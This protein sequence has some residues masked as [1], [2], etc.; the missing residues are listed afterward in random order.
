MTTSVEQLRT[1]LVAS[2]YLQQRADR[3]NRTIG[4]LA[5]YGLMNAA[6]IT[7]AAGAFLGIEIDGAIEPTIPNSKQLCLK[8]VSRAI[9]H[10]IGERED[11]EADAAMSQ[12]F[13]RSYDIGLALLSRIER[14]TSNPYNDGW[15]PRDIK[16]DDELRA[17]N[18]DDTAA[19]HAGNYLATDEGRRLLKPLEPSIAVGQG[20]CPL[21]GSMTSNGSMFDIVCDA[22]IDEYLDP[23]SPMHGRGYYGVT[24][25][26]LER[27][28]G[29]QPVPDM[30][31]E[32]RYGWELQV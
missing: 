2:P 4:Q 16:P 32:G 25:L 14:N 23:D 30:P 7:R 31:V 18:I 8:G 26:A 20:G 9:A 29:V 22:I 11:R 28:K 19:M 13:G 5:D 1:Q 12:M 21:I 24:E 17:R 27:I 10:R 6:M 3:T 15:L